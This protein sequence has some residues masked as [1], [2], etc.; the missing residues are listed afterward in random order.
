MENNIF[1][2]LFKKSKITGDLERE[3]PNKA[4]LIL[5]KFL[6]MITCNEVIP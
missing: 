4:L 6:K 1:Y 3:D 2:S 5:H